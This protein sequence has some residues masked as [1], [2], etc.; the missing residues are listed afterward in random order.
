[1]PTLIAALLASIPNVLIAI[2]SKLVTEKF[3][4][5]VLERVIVYALQK[6]AKLTINTID[7]ELVADMEKRLKEPAP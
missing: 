3:L 4:Q 6:A 1:M 2:L 5:S 7:D